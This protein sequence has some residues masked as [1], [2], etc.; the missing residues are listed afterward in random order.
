MPLIKSLLTIA[1]ATV[2][3]VGTAAAQTEIKFGHVGKPGSLL[4][5]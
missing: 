5:T 1:F 3:S 2:L 4:E